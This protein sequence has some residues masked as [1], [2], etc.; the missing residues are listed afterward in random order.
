M[1]KLR[2]L[3]LIFVCVVGILLAAGFAVFTVAVQ[4]FSRSK[5]APADAIP[6]QA[7]A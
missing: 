6:A 7:A 1:P 5:P 3:F 4:K 2:R